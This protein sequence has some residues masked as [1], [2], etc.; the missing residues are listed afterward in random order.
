MEIDKPFLIALLFMVAVTIGLVGLVV[1]FLVTRQRERELDLGFEDVAKPYALTTSAQHA[2]SDLVVKTPNP[3][4]WTYSFILRFPKHELNTSPLLVFAVGNS[5]DSVSRASIMLVIGNSNDM[6]IA[7]RKAGQPA[8]L[9]TEWGDIVSTAFCRVDVVDVPFHR[10]F[11]L[12]VV[13]DM[14][15]GLCTVYLDGHM[16][17]VFDVKQCDFQAVGGANTVRAMQKPV[18][19]TALLGHYMPSPIATFAGPH[20]PFSGVEF[21][22]AR[23]YNYLLTASDVR[24]NHEKNMEATYDAIREEARARADSTCAHVR[25]LATA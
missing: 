23:I 10:Y 24:K 20:T 16:N 4:V 22:H 7:L 6:Y 13:Y 1:Y 8:S 25:S 18:G 19:S 2:M 12:D 3:T 14:N 17:T 15:A 11:A 9:A 5:G 21:R